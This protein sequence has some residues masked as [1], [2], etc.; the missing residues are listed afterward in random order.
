MLV[1]APRCVVQSRVDGRCYSATAAWH[2]SGLDHAFPLGVN[3]AFQI[4]QKGPS[5]AFG[6]NL[7]GDVTAA[8]V[9]AEAALAC[10]ASPNILLFVGDQHPSRSSLPPLAQQLTTPF[11][12]YLV[13]YIPFPVQLLAGAHNSSDL[14]AAA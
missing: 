3:V 11:C 12:H 13:P 4:A 14:S 6:S 7:A 2:V 8:G 9:T 1:R 5:L 10:Q